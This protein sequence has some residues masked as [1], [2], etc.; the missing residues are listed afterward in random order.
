ML[1]DALGDPLYHSLPNFTVSLGSLFLLLEAL[2][3]Q[4]S[5]HDRHSV[6]VFGYYASRVL[7]E[8]VAYTLQSLD[9]KGCRMSDS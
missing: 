7:L 4:T 3:D 2:S 6:I 5:G 1:E 9:L 8:N